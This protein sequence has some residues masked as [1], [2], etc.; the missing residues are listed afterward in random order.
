M[1]TSLKCEEMNEDGGW[2]II[3]TLV[4]QPRL[5]WSRHLS[6]FASLTSH[7]HN[8]LLPPS[9]SPALWNN[10]QQPEQRLNLRLLCGEHKRAQCLPFFSPIKTCVA[11]GGGV[12]VELSD[13]LVGSVSG[14]GSINDASLHDL[15]LGG[16]GSEVMQMCGNPDKKIILP[17]HYPVGV[18]RDC[19]LSR[20]EDLLEIWA[21]CWPTKT[22]L[23]H[24]SLKVNTP[25]HSVH[26]QMHTVV[27]H[28]LLMRLEEN[29]H[30]EIIIYFRN[31]FFQMC[32]K[33][34]SFFL[35]LWFYSSSIEPQSF[36]SSLEFGGVP[37]GQSNTLQEQSGDSAV[38]SVVTMVSAAPLTAPCKFFIVY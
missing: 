1:V 15:R 16:G 3:P 31:N 24:T 8:L 34:K 18:Y 35:H 22:Q 14:G 32:A 10:G 38:C 28:T 12:T 29:L 2:M 4:L 21:R 7:L 26:T 17:F 11:S 30:W 25:A 19:V 23:F 27:A 9:S 37:A 6:L 20:C 36:S 13:T 5:F 33:L